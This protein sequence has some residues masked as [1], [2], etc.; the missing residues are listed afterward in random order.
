MIDQMFSGRS[1]P[2]ASTAVSSL[3]PPRAPAD[4]A[5]SPQSIASNL[6]ICTSASSLRSILGSSKAVAVMYTSA[7]C[8]PCTAVKPVFEELART[9]GTTKERIDFVLVEM[10]VGGANEVAGSDEFGGPVRATPTFVF[11]AKGKK[12]GECKGGDVGELKTQV[13]LLEMEAYPRAFLSRFLC[14]AANLFA[15][16][17]H[18]KLSLPALTKLSHSLSPVTYPV[19]PSLPTLS[20]KLASF[21]TDAS[22]TSP[23]LLPST[24]P[25]LTFSVIAYLTSLPTPPALPATPLP[26]TLTKDWTS[27]TLNALCVLPRTEWFPLLDLWRIGLAHDLPRLSP[28]FAT[29][30]PQL[31][32][33]DYLLAPGINSKPLLLTTLRLLSNALPSPVLAGILLGEKREEMTRVVVRALLAEDKGV[34]SC[35]AGLGWSVVGRLW[36]GRRGEGGEEWEVEVTSALV[37]ALRNEGESVEVGESFLGATERALADGVGAVHRLAATIGLL[38]FQSPHYEELQALVEVLGLAEVLREKEELV[39]GK[40]EVVEVLREVGVLCL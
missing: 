15:A 36:S 21:L 13:E 17:P 34:R 37:E 40:Q 26:P 39:K 16:H 10:G 38:L 6:Q 24:I 22:M 32:S 25:T 27:A 11:F 35:A 4:D 5:A 19:L 9:H 7:S 14:D 33:E 23:S 18:T 20:S 31:L 8:P 30:L 12:V 2:P 1:G 3:L 29:L 28:T